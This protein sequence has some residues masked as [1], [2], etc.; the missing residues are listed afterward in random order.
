MPC[1][2]MLLSG[3]LWA[4]LETLCEL[5]GALWALWGPPEALCK[6]GG[7]LGP[8]EALWDSL[9]RFSGVPNRLSG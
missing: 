9:G 3:A 7:S 8:S 5:S 6:F 2:V 4:S 1:H